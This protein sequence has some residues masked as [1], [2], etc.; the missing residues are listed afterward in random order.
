MA[1]TLDEI[2]QAIRADFV[3]NF[4]LQEAYALDASKTFDEQ[5]SKV[6]IEAIWTFVVASAIYLLELIVDQK[7]T[8]LESQIAAEYPFSIPWYYSRSLLFQLG[9]NVVFDET[10]YRF[11]Y[12][13]ADETKQIVKHVAVR[14]REM[15][16]VTKLQVYAAKINK[17]ALSP[18]EFSA[19][20]AYIRLIGAAGTHF[21][22]V[23]LAPD[24][25]TVN[26]TVNYDPQ[27]IAYS[28]DRLS[29]TGK[30][31]NEA[32]A[33]YLDG[34]KYGG[35][36]SRTKLVDAIQAASGVLDV[37]LGDVLLNGDL[38][39]AQK[40]ESP[41]GFFNATVI[42]VNYTPGYEY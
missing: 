27:L 39:N 42:T 18:D 25:L 30:P 31:V 2:K 37:V 13:L 26:L 36:L 28:G 4:T 15:S 34:I 14:Q 12:A 8:E 41:S 24:S 35:S 11:G 6:S 33:A 21:D 5:F 19:F 23:S 38:N 20:Q 17:A 7:T 3:S 22:F 40:F 29:G 32:I 1:R 16:G 9:D 10:T